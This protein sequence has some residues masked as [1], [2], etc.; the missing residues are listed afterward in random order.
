[1]FNAAENNNNH[2]INSEF[3]FSKKE[4]IQS[5]KHILA[6]TASFIENNSLWSEIFNEV[7]HNGIT[8]KGLYPTS[9]MNDIRENLS[10]NF[11]FVL[12][13]AYHGLDNNF[14]PG[15]VQLIEQITPLLK[16]RKNIN[17][18][19]SHVKPS[20]GSVSDQA[21]A[22][23]PMQAINMLHNEFSD[24]MNTNLISFSIISDHPDIELFINHMD[25]SNLKSNVFIKINNDFMKSLFTNTDYYLKH[26]V[27]IE[28]KLID[29]ESLF[30][31]S[32]A[33]C[34]CDPQKVWN[35]LMQLSD[36]NVVIVFEDETHSKTEGTGVNPIT[37]QVTSENA[38]QLTAHID[39][40]K[41]I[42]DTSGENDFDKEKLTGAIKV[43]IRMLDNLGH[44]IKWQTKTEEN[45]FNEKRTINIEINNFGEALKQTNNRSKIQ[46][47][48]I[49]DDIINL[50][51]EQ[52]FQSSLELSIERGSIDIIDDAYLSQLEEKGLSKLLMNKIKKH[53]LRNTCIVS[54]SPFSILPVN[55]YRTLDL[56][57][58]SFLK[59]V[60][61]MDKL[62]FI[63]PKLLFKSKNLRIKKLI[64]E[65]TW[66]ILNNDK[67][68]KLS[69]IEMH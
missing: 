50:I 52:I 29:K 59:I 48:T 34:M 38:T 65:N 43:A 44:M 10:D 17:I 22:Q 14:Y 1:M 49:S 61:C 8:I 16:K 57:Y 64:L 55:Q 31:N 12:G 67:Y 6:K 21:A 35:K 5:E 32:H 2:S 7:L 39:L 54:I 51:N 11:N 27:L 20:T 56:N 37:Q 18:D 62:S 58:I 53:G 15:M 4:Q 47:D 25:R 24:Y 60:K 9:N 42:S 19:L 63:E 69:M 3:I 26:E 23:S 46:V 68:E 41:Y 30:L 40:I 13:N 33:Y 28:D 66:N 45:R 36:K